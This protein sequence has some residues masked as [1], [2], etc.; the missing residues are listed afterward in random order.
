MDFPHAT[1]M[2]TSDYNASYHFSIPFTIQLSWVFEALTMSPPN[3]STLL[4]N[5]PRPLSALKLGRLVLDPLYPDDEFYP[6]EP[7]PTKTSDNTDETA[8]KLA[9]SIYD[10]AKVE[11][12]RIDNFK[13]TLDRSK[14]T[15]L[16]LILLKI[17]SLAW[18]IA[19]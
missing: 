11:K 6:P 16:E 3:V 19:D 14:G 4:L 1:L 17:L 15:K 8:S 12:L 7:E 13:T 5:H 18:Q 10:N 2:N 9:T